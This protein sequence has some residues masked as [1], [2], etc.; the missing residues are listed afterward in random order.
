MEVV[1]R[2]I[3]RL[4]CNIPA[5]RFNQPG[6]MEV[7]PLVTREDK[8]HQNRQGLILNMGWIP[9]SVRNPTSRLRIERVDRQKFTCFVSRLDELRN[10]TWFRGNAYHQ[11]RRYYTCADL[12][13]LGKSS[14]LLN[15]EQAS[16][17]VLERLHET[18]IYDERSSVRYGVDSHCTEPY[19]WAKT[20][21]G[22][23]QLYKMPWD[24]KN[25]AKH[26]LAASLF[27]FLVGASI[28]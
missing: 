25:D 21:A 14:E 8:N 9:E 11:G 6:Y 4:E 13:D 1:G 3:H 18:G 7:L 23:L 28:F 12:E 10:H 20:E 26:Y 24:Y 2:P 15:R 17:A 27:S 22:A 16:V 5:F 19:P